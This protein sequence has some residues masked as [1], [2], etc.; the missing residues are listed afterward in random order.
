MQKNYINFLIGIILLFSFNVQATTHTVTVSDFSFSPSTLSVSVGDVINWNW[1][2][3]SHTTTSTSV[4]A[5]A[6]TWDNAINSGST[7]FSYTV[8][9]SGTYN[10]QCSIHPSSMIGSF[11]ATVTGIAP[12]VSSSFLVNTTLVS[13]NLQVTYKLETSSVVDVRLLDMSGK[14]LQK[15]TSANHTPGTYAE[16]YSLGNL[17]KGEYVIELHSKD[18]VASRKIVIQ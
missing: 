1:A 11:T 9:M 4:P 10:Y 6:A 12:V 2:S 8:T 17:A 7:S 14:E 15:F 5:G 13:N 16:T 18:M 3:G